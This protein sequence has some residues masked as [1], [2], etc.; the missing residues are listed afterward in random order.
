MHRHILVCRGRARLRRTVD[1]VSLS[2][3]SAF[4]T[5][6]IACSEHHESPKLHEQERAVASIG[7]VGGLDAAEPSMV[8]TFEYLA[9]HYVLEG[10]SFANLCDANAEVRDHARSKLH[11]LTTGGQAARR[12]GREDASSL[13]RVMGIWLTDPGHSNEGTV[14][15][16]AASPAGAG[17]DGASSSFLRPATDATSASPAQAADAGE[18][19]A[20]ASAREDAAQ[21]DSDDEGEDIKPVSRSQMLANKPSDAGSRSLHSDARLS[22]RLEGSKMETSVSSARGLN[23]LEVELLQLR[24][25]MARSRLRDLTDV[26]RSHIEGVLRDHAEKGDLQTSATACCLL[27][28]VGV[29]IDRFFAT[30]TISAYIGEHQRTTILSG[31]DVAP[32]ICF[33]AVGW[34]W[35]QP[36]CSATATSSHCSTRP[37]YASHRPSYACHSQ[38]L[39]A[40]NH[41]TFH[42][43]C[44][45]CKRVIDA[46]PYNYCTKCRETVSS[47]TICGLSAKGLFIFCT[48]CGHG[49]HADCLSDYS[50]S[51]VPPTVEQ[52][53]ESSRMSTP[54]TVLIK[55]WLW[56]GSYDEYGSDREDDAI[57]RKAAG[58]CPAGACGHASCILGQYAPL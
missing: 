31:A 2:T 24:L 3:W 34:T 21:D 9:T 15:D 41:I 48:A 5:A 12:V 23:S 55:S 8:P 56:E 11:Q 6:H 51:F 19:A 18:S 54:G 53:R 40:Q 4:A 44:A 52:S 17:D 42:S 22:S 32:Q 50:N 10:D 39:C 46:A 29:H 13:W 7:F 27:A 28:T 30:R 45:R 1:K 43:A 57:Q 49:A 25:S 26:V 58:M 35:R 36:R 38:T 14:D 33:V 20:E 37:R 47:C 16:G